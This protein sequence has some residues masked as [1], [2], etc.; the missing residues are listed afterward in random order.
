[1]PCVFGASSVCVPAAHVSAADGVVAAVAGAAAKADA[2]LAA[3]G[4]L[5]AAVGGAREWEEVEGE[6]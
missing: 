4:L 2:V 3:V 1:V 5:G 6:G